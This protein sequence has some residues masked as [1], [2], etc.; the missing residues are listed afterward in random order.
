MFDTLMVFLK[1]FFEEKKM[2]LKSPADDKKKHAETTQHAS[3]FVYN[4]PVPLSLD[5][6]QA[7]FLLK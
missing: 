4:S 2:F 6:V 7:P 3:L 5:T 1:A